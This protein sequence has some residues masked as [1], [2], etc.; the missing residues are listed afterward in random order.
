LYIILSNLL[1]VICLNPLNPSQA[2]A[3]ALALPAAMGLIML[4]GWHVH[5][6]L[7]N[8]TTIEYQEVKLQGNHFSKTVMLS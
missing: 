7:A 8:K 3:F 2:T 5:L 4:L 1:E 6:A